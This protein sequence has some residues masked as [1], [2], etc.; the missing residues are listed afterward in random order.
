MRRQIRVV[1]IVSFIFGIALGAL[2]FGCE[3]DNISAL[4]IKESVSVPSASL[5]SSSETSGAKEF[6]PTFYR[7]EAVSIIEKE[8]GL[9]ALVRGEERLLSVKNVSAATELTE[10]VYEE[11]VSK[12]VSPN[13][14]YIYFCQQVTAD[15]AC[16]NYLYDVLNEGLY[17]IEH[18]DSTLVTDTQTLSQRWG[19]DGRLQINDLVSAQAITPWLMV[20]E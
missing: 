3:H 10:G 17:R 8:D 4:P 6:R 2:L 20:H 18:D 16:I 15:A 14:Y 7:E 19:S 5:R 13:G 1:A 12:S 11:I 9:Y